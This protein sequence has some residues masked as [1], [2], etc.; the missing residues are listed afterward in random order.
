MLKSISRRSLLTA[1]VGLALV[2]R[3][4]PAWAQLPPLAKKASYKVGFA[5]TDSNN[6]WRLAQTESMQSEANPHYSS[7]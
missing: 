4:R 7:F 6:P 2:T 1:T 5:Q 3:M